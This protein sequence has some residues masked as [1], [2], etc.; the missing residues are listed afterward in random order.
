M[1]MYIYTHTYICIYIYNN[2]GFG[3]VGCCWRFRKKPK[4][5]LSRPGEEDEFFEATLARA[6]ED[7]YAVA[8]KGH[9]YFDYIIGPCK[10]LD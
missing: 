2:A 9:A 1:Y 7:A 4:K 6:C 3:A 5:L 10:G 8:Q